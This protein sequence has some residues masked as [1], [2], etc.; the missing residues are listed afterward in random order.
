MTGTKIIKLKLEEGRASETLPQLMGDD[1]MAAVKIF[2]RIEYGG[3]MHDY[4]DEALKAT[5]KMNIVPAAMMELPNLLKQEHSSEENYGVTA[6]L[7]MTALMQNSPYSMFTVPNMPEVDGLGFKL[8]GDKRIIALGY[9]GKSLGSHMEGG[10][11]HVMQSATDDVGLGMRGGEIRIDGN[12]GHRIGSRME[13]GKI[14]VIGYGC[15]KVADG[16]KGGKIEIG[17]SVG[18]GLGSHMEGGEIHV[19]GDV[20]MKLA[21]FMR[22]GKI[23]VDGDIVSVSGTTVIAGGKSFLRMEDEIFG[24]EIWNK[25]ERI[26]PK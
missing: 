21:F 17:G 2:K 7:Y 12:A 4:Y 15:D 11:I 13:K 6:G 18:R 3:N 24:G 22:G 14:T 16:M 25:G 9:V 10:S 26:F 8:K 23:T 19:K 5:K 20:G 1:L